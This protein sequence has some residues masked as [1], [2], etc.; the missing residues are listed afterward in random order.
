MGDLTPPG[1]PAGGRDEPTHSFP[2]SAPPPMFGAPPAPP[3]QS[4]GTDLGLAWTSFGVSLAWCVP[5]V[6]LVGAVLGIVAL[7]RRRLPKRWIAV[8]ALVLGLLGTGLQVVAAASWDDFREGLQSG[9]QDAAD[10][11]AQEARDT[12]EPSEVSPISLTEGDCVNDPS[13]RGIEGDEAAEAMMVTLLPCER[14]HDFEVFA[15]FRLD[16]G[17]YPGSAA[18]D[19]KARRCFSRFG[20]FVGKQYSESVL[21]LYYYFPTKRSWSLSGDRTIMCLVGHPEHRVTG[22]LKNARR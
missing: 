14:K 16:D 17:D 6:P 3:T 8:A 4:A 12:G 13:L 11:D 15:T 18:I 21:E 2:S 20:K 22:S 9:M 7:V 1:P 5:L 10:R 19:R